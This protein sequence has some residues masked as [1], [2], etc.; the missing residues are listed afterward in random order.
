[1]SHELP[2]RN[3]LVRNSPMTKNPVPATTEDICRY[4]IMNF[5]C[6]QSERGSETEREEPRRAYFIQIK[7]ENFNTLVREAKL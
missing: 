1:M 6:F 4:R 7:T 5:R 3:L 2:S